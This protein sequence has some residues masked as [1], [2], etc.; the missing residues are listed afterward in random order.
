MSV[1]TLYRTGTSGAALKPHRVVKVAGGKIV[2]AAG[3]G[4]MSIGVTGYVVPDAADLRVDYA[5]AGIVEVQCS[6]AVSPGGRLG[7]A[8]NDGRVDEASGTNPVIGIALNEIDSQVN[9]I[10]PMLIAPGRN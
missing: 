2:H 10:I 3:A 5:V 9:D 8:S 6:A 7:V 1:V 4:D